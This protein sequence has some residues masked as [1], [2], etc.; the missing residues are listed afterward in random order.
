M[1]C[2]IVCDTDIDINMTQTTTQGET[3]LHSY[4]DAELST[5]EA[6]EGSGHGLIGGTVSPLALS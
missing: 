4:N 5:E 3:V 6:V 2:Y 1:H